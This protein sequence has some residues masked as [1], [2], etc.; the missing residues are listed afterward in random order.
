MDENINKKRNFY[1]NQIN[2][3]LIPQIV[4]KAEDLHIAVGNQKYSEIQCQEAFDD[5]RLYGDSIESL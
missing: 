5:L 3:Q 1:I 4:Q 2:E